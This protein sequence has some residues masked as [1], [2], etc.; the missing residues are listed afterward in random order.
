M[1]RL[2]I[3]CAL[4][5]FTASAFAQKAN[6]KKVK[7][8]IEY[9]TTPVAM[10]LSNMKPEE[11]EE[12]RA[13]LEPALTHPESATM[14]DTWKYAARFKY[15]DMKKML[16]Q[17]IA[18]N[19]EFVDLE[20]FFSNQADI[21]EYLENYIKY[22]N[23]PNEKGKYDMK[24]EERNKEL[25]F[26]QQ[27]AQN[28]RN[29]LF[30]GA[31][32]IVYKNP[33]LTVKLLDRYYESFDNP[34][35]A[36]LDLKAKDP[37][38]KEGAY[39]YATALKATG[40]DEQKVMDY[41]QQA[42]DSKNGPLAMQDIITFYKDKGDK[43]AESKAYEQAYQKFPD[44]LIF[45]INLAQ[46][47]VLEKRYDEAIRYCDEII[48]KM[49]NGTISQTDADGNPI[50][51]TKY[52]YYFRAVSFYNLE[53]YEDAFNAFVK[54][55]EKKPDYIDCIVG[56]GNTATRIA[57]NNKDK[58]A[59]ADKWYAEAVKYYEQAKEMEPDNSDMWGYP[60]YA[61]YYNMGNMAKAKLYSK[62]N[63]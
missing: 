22:L 1:K 60:L 4:A 2:I 29:N 42:I 57:S 56:A 3:M 17:R 49:E 34:L 25:L 18:N 6:V 23:T 46:N 41:L 40:A 33:Q 27:N 50:E 35:F 21:V 53:K 8:K 59:I 39:I 19:N 44:Q 9:A 63:K 12:L 7:N 36:G 20:A 51:A 54:G 11:L 13:L 62:Y 37:Y 15:Y 61:S 24:E 28:P 26:W 38:Y 52:P 5:G 30:I 47:C 48:A 43:A 32:N 16:E 45:G 10:D 31:S 14:A 58:K 55:I